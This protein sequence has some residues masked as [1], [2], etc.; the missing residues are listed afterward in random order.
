M[1]PPTRCSIA[2][3]ASVRPPASRAP[4]Q[5]FHVL[6]KPAGPACN[7]DC[8][9]CFYLEKERLYPG[10]ASFAM[11]DEVLESFTRQYLEAHPYPEV[12]FS[13]QGGEPTLLGVE[14]F[15]RAVAIQQR[16]AGGRKVGNAIQT[17]G[18]LLDD[19]WGAFLAEYGFLVGL[20]IDGPAALHDRYRRDRGNGPTF[21]AV[22]RGL[23]VLQKH[24]VDFNTLTVVQRDNADHPLEIY[25]FL[26]GIGS[27]YMQFIPIVERVADAPGP[28]GLLLVGPDAPDPASVSPW[29]V[30]PGQYGSFLCAIFDEWVRD[31]VG[32]YYVQ[33]FDVALEAW[34]GLP[35]TLCIFAET[36][37]RA[38]AVEHNGDIYA[39][40]HYVYPSHR[41][42]NLM[43]GALADAVD[44]AFQ[45]AF[46][47]A[48]RDTL[49]F[50][51]QECDVLFACQG[52]CP[53][54]RFAKARD[55]SRS[56]NYLCAAYKQFF[57]HID[58]AM[59][60]MAGELAERRPPANV[61]AWVAETDRAA[62]LSA[63]GRNDPCPC[64][65]GK[66]FKACCSGA[67]RVSPCGLT[68]RMQS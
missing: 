10:A 29:S 6:A 22:M 40:D 26:K 62:A 18:V 30:Q 42:G 43:E 41:I 51:C 64:G 9:Y 36:C 7:L 37:G 52:E 56:L 44:G 2:P 1:S 38:V 50:D 68:G 53:K 49:P 14:F 59:Q 19:R 33:A 13:W 28:D 58:P 5:P 45:T 3:G 65:S 63:A 17:N 23:G 8:T 57:R 25:R 61:M 47:R 32:R 39:C 60:F 66:K 16:L 11:A 55:G 4:G 67:R 54:H 12:T 46:S 21:G 34:C 24:G 35:S 20:S 48:K 31:D 27:R 15:E